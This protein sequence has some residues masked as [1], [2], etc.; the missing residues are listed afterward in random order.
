MIADLDAFQDGLHC[1]IV[2]RGMANPS[3]DCQGS[4]IIPVLC[5]ITS[6]RCHGPYGS[7]DEHQDAELRRSCESHYPEMLAQ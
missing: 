2:N 6:L 4:R 7:A 5:Y 1:L 3:I